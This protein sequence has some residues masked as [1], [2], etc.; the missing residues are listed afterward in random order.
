VILPD[1]TRA[2]LGLALRTSL[3]NSG[4]SCCH[5]VC[6][7]DLGQNAF[8]RQPGF[9]GCRFFRDASARNSLSVSCSRVACVSLVAVKKHGV[10]GFRVA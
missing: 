1:E 3:N 4:R 8:Q 9:P 10:D 6:R 2:A 7:I 5:R